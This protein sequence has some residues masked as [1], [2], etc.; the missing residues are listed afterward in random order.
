MTKDKA[1]G[2]DSLATV[3]TGALWGAERGSRGRTL[4]PGP[5]GSTPQRSTILAEFGGMNKLKLEKQQAVISA[6]VEGNSIRS[7][8]R[9][10]GIHRDTIMRL[11]VRV[12]HGCAHLMDTSMRGLI[13]RRVQLDEIWCYVGKKQRRLTEKDDSIRLGDKWTFV[14]IDSDSKL[15]P[16]YRVGQRNAVTAQAFVSD[17]ES[18]LLNRVQL[19]TDSLPAYVDSI[20]L[21]GQVL[22]LL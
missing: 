8:E 17:L 21:A 3:L 5:W 22:R 15:I 1:P 11:G 10:T 9:M 16:A 6:L 13:C 2:S 20:A 14:A 18:R 12:G 4:H 19:S 7:V